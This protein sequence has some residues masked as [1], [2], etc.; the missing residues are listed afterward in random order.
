VSTT[1]AASFEQVDVPKIILLYLDELSW[2][3]NPLRY[4]NPGNDYNLV[5]KHAIISHKFFG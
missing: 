3:I 4:T 5:R 2:I 1:G